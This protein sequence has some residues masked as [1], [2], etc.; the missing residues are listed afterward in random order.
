MIGKFSCP[1]VGV[2]L[3]TESADVKQL[4]SESFSNSNVDN[5]SDSGSDCSPKEWNSDLEASSYEATHLH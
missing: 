3:R 2:I 4:S 1:H 5:R